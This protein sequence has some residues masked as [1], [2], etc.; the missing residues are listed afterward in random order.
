MGAS[1]A[2][3]GCQ[4]SQSFSSSPENRREVREAQISAIHAAGAL[5]LLR[6][7]A[8][9][10][11]LRIHLN[12]GIHEHLRTV[13]ISSFRQYQPVFDALVANNDLWNEASSHSIAQFA[14][15]L[16]SD[17]NL[18][19]SALTL[20]ESVSDIDD[21]DRPDALHDVSAQLPGMAELVAA[22]SAKRAEIAHLQSEL[23]RDETKRLELARWAEILWLDGV[24]LQMRL[25]EAL[26]L[27]GIPNES[28]DPT[29]HTQ[30]L[31]GT[32]AGRSFLFEVTGSNGSIGIDKG[33][34]LLQWL[35]ECNDPANTKGI[36]IAN[37]FRKHPPE[38]QHSGRR[39]SP[40][41]AVGSRPL[42]EDPSS[43]VDGGDGSDG[44]HRLDLRSLET[45]RSSAEGRASADAASHRRGKEEE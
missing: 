15:T 26:T 20:L 9:L 16:C 5:P 39:L 19:A 33:G 2:L 22:S 21:A 17:E 3:R 7:N 42:D 25:S 31:A 38:R 45:A 6:K 44:V 23:E 8:T 24:P 27:L 4:S 34:Q 37:A 28:N 1:R 30:D 32:F 41:H 14:V 12:A 43:A 35:A 36:L 29:G 10:G 11:D 40:R 18:K 13:T